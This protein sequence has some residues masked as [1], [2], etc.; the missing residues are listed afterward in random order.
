MT[1]TKIFTA[2]MVLL[3]LSGVAALPVGAD[4]LP[5]ADTAKPERDWSIDFTPYVW[6][7]NIDADIGLGPIKDKMGVGIVSILEHLKGM[8]MAD[9]T[10][11][12]K[13]VGVIGDGMWAAVTDSSFT[14]A[15]TAPGLFGVANVDARLSLAFGTGAAFF[16]FRPMEKLTL[17]PYIGARWWRVHT[18]VNFIDVGGI[19]PPSTSDTV[20]TWADPVFGLRL[21]YDITESWRFKF[22]ADV[23]GG[24]SKVSW[25][26]LV[27]GAYQVTPWLGLELVYRVMGVDYQPFPEKFELKLNGVVVGVN[28]H[29]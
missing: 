8:A 29:Y 17:D 12:Y 16:R 11:R 14:P 9:L 5:G 23:G 4:E 13:R 28:F 15:Q 7:V 19:L 18:T 20:T 10:L 21:N 27:G 25:Q 26:A 3:V 22:A 1:K 6:V 2:G 24:V